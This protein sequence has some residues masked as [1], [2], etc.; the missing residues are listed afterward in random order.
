MSEQE[1]VSSPEQPTANNR[2]RKWAVIAI[3]IILLFALAIGSRYLA[4][5]AAERE[6][7]NRAA[8]PFAAAVLPLLDLR[9]KNILGDH[10]TLQRVVDTV[11]RDKGFSFA[12]ILD[13][14][15]RV[16]AASDRNVGVGN[17]YGDFKAGEAVEHR[18][19]G[20][21]EIIGP[22]KQNGVVYGAVVLRAP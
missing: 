9:S 16:I 6:G 17:K 7:V 4:V 13:P 12:A 18:E 22:I 19:A 11:V 21:H 2:W 20:R 5:A 1:N 14:E 15:G 3:A 10:S 8:S